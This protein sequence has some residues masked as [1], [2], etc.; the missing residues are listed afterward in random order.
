MLN[1]FEIKDYSRW[2]LYI[3][4]FVFIYMETGIVTLIFAIITIIDREIKYFGRKLEEK[5]HE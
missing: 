4:M 5:L 2:V 1:L 3:F